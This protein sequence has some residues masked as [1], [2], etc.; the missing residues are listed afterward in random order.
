MRSEPTTRVTKID[1]GNGSRSDI[2]PEQNALRIF[3]ELEDAERQLDLSI[4][5][6]VPEEKFQDALVSSGISRNDISRIIGDMKLEQVCIEGMG[7]AYRRNGM[8]W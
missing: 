3:D 6:A 2:S 7:W 1:L 5:P 4:E 8:G